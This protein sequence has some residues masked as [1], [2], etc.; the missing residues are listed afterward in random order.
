VFL[1]THVG[2]DQEIAVCEIVGSK[3]SAQE[4]LPIFDL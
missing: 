2:A 1:D 3:V 4:Y